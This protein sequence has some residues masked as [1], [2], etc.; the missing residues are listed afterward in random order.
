MNIMD[1]SPYIR[2]FFI[3]TLA[4]LTVGVANAAPLSVRIEEPDLY[5]QLN[6]NSAWNII[7]DGEID[8]DAPKRVAAALE[9]AGENGADV[10]INSPGGNLVAGMKI[11]WLIRQSGANTHIG[12]LSPD[13][14]FKLGSKMWVKTLP[15]GCYSACAL[16]FLGGVYRY[17]LSESQYGVHRFSS[18]TK[19]SDTDLDTA[20]IISAAISNYIRDMDVDPGLFNLMAQSGKDRIRLL[21]KEDLTSLNIVNNGRKRPEWSIEVADSGQYLRGVQDTVYGEGKA[22]FFCDHSEIMFLSL[23]QSGASKAKSI[24][25]GGWHHSLLI[26]DEVIPLADPLK[27]ESNGDEISNLFT[28]NQGQALA[29]AAAT[30]FGHAMQLGRDAPTFVGYVIDIPSVSTRKVST[31]IRNCFRP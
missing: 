18:T 7:L 19:P 1:T 12:S 31:F 9:K 5:K 4:F 20:Q 11:G 17:A 21:T 24:A 14:T 2:K 30:R 25:A 23:Y 15:G 28:L 8:V 27:S 26:D 10:Y 22:V 16:A 29:I 6:Q 13:P 3:G